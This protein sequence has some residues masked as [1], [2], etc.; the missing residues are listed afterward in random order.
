MTTKSG[1]SRVWLEV[2]NYLFEENIM[3]T[4][5]TN[6]IEVEQEALTLRSN[7]SLDIRRVFDLI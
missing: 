5:T 2:T 4:E 3:D 7:L 6:I 1:F